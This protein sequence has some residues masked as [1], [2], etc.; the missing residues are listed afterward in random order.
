M[1]FWKYLRLIGSVIVLVI[2]VL[3]VVL[4]LLHRP[5][6][7]DYTPPPRSPLALKPQAGPTGL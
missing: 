7:D 5:D 1:N 3:T 6:S 2:A 4:A